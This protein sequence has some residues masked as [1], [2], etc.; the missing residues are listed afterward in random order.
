MTQIKTDTPDMQ[1]NNRV[2]KQE[3]IK[4][5]PVAWSCSF[6]TARVPEQESDMMSY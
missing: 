4:I 1:D 3:E 2:P 6:R 5:V